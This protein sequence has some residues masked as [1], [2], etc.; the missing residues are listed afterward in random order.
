MVQSVYLV[1]CVLLIIERK[2]VMQHYVVHC[3]G[4][5]HMEQVAWKESGLGV[6]LYVHV[7][8][9]FTCSHSVS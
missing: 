2:I 4:L 1:C 7:N 5:L 3:N 6:S 9:V 8:S